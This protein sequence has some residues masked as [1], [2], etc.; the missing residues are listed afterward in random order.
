MNK[1]KYI[2]ILFFFLSLIIFG[3]SSLKKDMRQEK[4]RRKELETIV[5]DRDKKAEK[6]YEE[7]VKRQYEIQTKET[8][9]R[10][11]YLEKQSNIYNGV[12]KEFFLKRWFSK[13][14]INNKQKKPENIQL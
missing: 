4:H 1:S 13:K 2:V 3:C 7:A 6:A 14:K 8:Q 11:D 12:K 10:I 9:K 5:K